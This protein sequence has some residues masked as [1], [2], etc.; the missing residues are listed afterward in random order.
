MIERLNET[1]QGRLPGELRLKNITTME[2]ANKYLEEF[3]IPQLN[4]K[5]GLPVE[6]CKSV[7][8]ASPS[9]EKINTILAIL[10]PRKLDNGSSIKFKKQYYQLYD[11]NNQLSCFINGTEAL[12]IEAFDKE[13]YASIN[14][15][16]YYLKIK[17]VHKEV[18]PNF[19]EEISKPDEKQKYIPPMSHPWKAASFKKQ[20][21]KAHT[22]KVYA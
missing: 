1:V 10:T 22:K 12:V 11:E 7:F 2:E 17:K 19:D 15:K 4:E 9:Q 18:S 13:L 3:F 21:E 6:N 8:E 16:I 5:F 20:M 14:E